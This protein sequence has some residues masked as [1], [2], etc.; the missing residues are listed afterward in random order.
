MEP[1]K[2]IPTVW[3][4]TINIPNLFSF[5]TNSEVRELKIF[6]EMAHIFEALAQNDTASI[7]QY[8][9]NQ[10]VGFE[11][12]KHLRNLEKLAE[13]N[14]DKSVEYQ[15][16]YIKVK[17]ASYLLDPIIRTYLSYSVENY[18]KDCLLLEDLIS[19]LE[20]MIETEKNDEM[21]WYYSVALDKKANINQQFDETLIEKCILCIEK[22]NS[23]KHKKA[24][25]SFIINTYYPNLSTYPK[26]EYLEKLQE[27]VPT[28]PWNYEGCY[29]VHRHKYIKKNIKNTDYFNIQD[30]PLL[31]ICNNSTLDF[32]ITILPSGSIFAQNASIPLSI[33]QKLLFQFAAHISPPSPPIFLF[34][35]PNVPENLNREFNTILRRELR[36]RGLCNSEGFLPETGF[37]LSNFSLDDLGNLQ[38]LIGLKVTKIREINP[39]NCDYKNLYFTSK[40]I[41]LIQQKLNEIAEV[42]AKNLSNILVKYNFFNQENFRAFCVAYNAALSGC[43]LSCSMP[44]ENIFYQLEPQYSKLLV[45]KKQLEGL[46]PLQALWLFYK[47]LKPHELGLVPDIVDKIKK[48]VLSCLE[49]AYEANKISEFTHLKKHNSWFELA[50]AI[51]K[52][53]IAKKN[54]LLIYVGTPIQNGKNYSAHAI[55][56]SIKWLP[57]QTVQIIITNGGLGVRE[58]HKL[59]EHQV[60]NDRKEY[61]YA[62][63]EP[64]ELDK[65]EYKEALEHYI[66]KLISLQYTDS[67]SNSSVDTDEDGNIIGT[68]SHTFLNELR[69]VY[70]CSTK[71]SQAEGYFRGRGF[72]EFKIFKRIDLKETFLSQFTGNCTVHNLKKSLQITF[73]MNLLTF[74]LFEDTLVLGLDSIITSFDQNENLFDQYH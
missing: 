67:T 39:Q 24:I 58:F 63:F 32:S 52:D 74:G 50:Q 62:A 10:E 51:V 3:F 4:S 44:I 73:D 53:F 59:A 43:G 36:T 26:Y 20:G 12:I 48:S 21:W 68:N 41:L 70:L 72:K 7:T 14:K 17:L 28:F 69:N 30:S 23:E 38:K 2:K 15:Q 64:F 40:E 19:S 49:I 16:F 11:T 45:I 9:G 56:A 71:E 18:E 55:Y 22:I 66:Y 57:D 5:P 42:S 37:A 1:V 27:L 29:N 34:N 6:D 60:R 33:S 46:L 8:F 61:H 47:C 54:N 65:T 35:L 13:K 31:Q 25:L